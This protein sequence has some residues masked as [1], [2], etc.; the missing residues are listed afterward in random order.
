MF[1]KRGMYYGKL[2][3][4]AAEKAENSKTP[5]WWDR[6]MR[7][8]GYEGFEQNKTVAPTQINII[9]SVKKDAQDFGF[10]EGEIIDETEEV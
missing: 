3:D 10:E 7:L 2:L 9:G 1:E 5:E 8:S 4:I 6:V